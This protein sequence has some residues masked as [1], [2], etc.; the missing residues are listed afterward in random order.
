MEKEVKTKTCVDCPLA[1]ATNPVPCFKGMGTI[2]EP[3][4][5]IV[6]D[7]PRTVLEP[8]SKKLGTQEINMLN[9]LLQESGLRME[10]CYVTSLVKCNTPC[11]K[12]ATKFTPAEYAL[13]KSEELKCCMNILKYELETIKPKI[14][15]AMGSSVLKYFMGP[16]HNLQKSEGVPLKKDNYIVIGTHAPEEVLNKPDKFENTRLTY[17]K[18]KTWLVS[19]PFTSWVDPKAQLLVTPTEVFEKLLWL[20]EQKEWACDIE[21]DGLE[22][23]A[24]IYSIAFSTGEE[25]F[26]FPFRKPD[27]TFFWKDQ[28]L[29]GHLHSALQAVF[30]NDALKIFHNA[31]FDVLQLKTFGIEVNN[32]ADTYLLYYLIDETAKNVKLK[33]LIWKILGMGGYE[34]EYDNVTASRSA[35]GAQTDILLKYN[36]N[37]AYATM[38]L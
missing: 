32:F 10:Q 27:G 36:A 3:S 34:T 16:Q 2:A 1:N 7:T 18:I 29:Y 25:T 8:L 13:P 22:L 30:A 37:D 17:Q 6:F 31:A 12:Q 9:R 11:S 14:I 38:L 5:F 15:V 33:Y 24:N 23:T 21:T 35:K 20:R 4:L 26:A 19:D 28:L